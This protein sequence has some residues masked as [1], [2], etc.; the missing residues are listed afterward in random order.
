MVD[1]EQIRRLNERSS[2]YNGPIKAIYIQDIQGD[3][4]PFISYRNVNIKT[5]GFDKMPVMDFVV[6]LAAMEIYAVNIGA[7]AEFF[8]CYDIVGVDLKV[9]ATYSDAM[10]IM[11]I[12]VFDALL[13]AFLPFELLDKNALE[14]MTKGVMDACEQNRIPLGSKSKEII[15]HEIERCIEEEINKN[16]PMNLRD[17][18]LS[19]WFFDDERLFE[20]D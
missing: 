10:G 17:Y 7:I 9:K 4:I 6:K 2:L 8:D 11:F 20:I 3:D 12:S 19:E 5:K 14:N 13:A 18:G 15:S 1:Y 16:R